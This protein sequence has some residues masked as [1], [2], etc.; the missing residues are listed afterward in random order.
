M[1][2]P[3]PALRFL[4]G[5][6]EMGALIREFDWRSAGLGHPASWPASLKT[7]VGIMLNSAAPLYIAWGEHFVQLYNDAYR[8]ILGEL[9]HPEALGGTTPETWYEI[10]DF[11]G[12]LFDS[13]VSSGQ[14]VAMQNTLLTMLRHGYPEECYFNF[15]Y[16]PLTDELGDIKG[17]IVTGLEVTE[18]FIDARRAACVKQLVQGLSNATDVSQVSALLAATVRDFPDDL[19]F[20]VWYLVGA[21]RTGLDLVSVAG[22]ARGSPLSPESLDPATAPLYAGQLRLDAPV[23]IE[24]PL[25]DGVLHLEGQAV[26]PTSLSVQPLCGGGSRLPDGYLVLAFNPKRPRDDAQRMFLKEVATQLELAVRRL[27]RYDLERRE[28]QHQY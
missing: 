20:A 17:V 16:S 2:D 6:G 10:W 7:A 26:T 9:K 21:D 24:L 8:L 3:A 12:P 4:R 19:P 28:S 22:I 5:G 27:N 18:K 11:V 14:A 1:H 13:V 25:D 15:S 23:T